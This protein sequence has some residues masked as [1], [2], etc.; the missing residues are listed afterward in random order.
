MINKEKYNKVKI[1]VVGDSCIDN[2]TYGSV[3]RLAPEAPVPVFNPLSKITNAG[4][5]GN[6]VANLKALG[7]NV[8]FGDDAAEWIFPQINIERLQSEFDKPI[9]SLD[10]DLTLLFRVRI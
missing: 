5:A 7:V 8:Y 9:G 4:M 1:L 6:V 3:V 2:F 10:A